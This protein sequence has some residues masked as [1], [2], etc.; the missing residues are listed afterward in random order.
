MRYVLL[1]F[2]FMV[3][4]AQ[5]LGVEPPEYPAGQYCTPAGDMFEGLVVNPDH[6]CH[7]VKMCAMSTDEE[8]HQTPYVAEDKTCNQWCHKSHCGCPIPCCDEK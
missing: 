7:C 8:G 6:P 1:L 4:S 2:A 5:E 3:V